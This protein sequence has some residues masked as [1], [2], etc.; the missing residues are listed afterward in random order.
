MNAATVAETLFSSSTPAPEA[1]SARPVGPCA[2]ATAAASAATSAVTMAVSLA[3]TSI[4]P[5]APTLESAMNARTL[6]GVQVGAPVPGVH[7]M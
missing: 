4:A 3:R 6:I 2:S 7:P 1:E 5:P